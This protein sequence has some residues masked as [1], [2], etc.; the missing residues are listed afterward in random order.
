MDVMRKTII[1]CLAFCGLGFVGISANPS[2]ITITQPGLSEGYVAPANKEGIAGP[3]YGGLTGDVWNKRYRKLK[4]LEIGLRHYNIQWAGL[5]SS[6]LPSSSTP[7]VCPAGYF[8][9]PGSPEEKAAHHYK[10]Y[11]CLNVRTVNLFDNML[12]RDAGVGIQSMAILWNTPPI[13]QDSAC[14]G[15]TWKGAIE[16]GGCVPRDDAMDD[17]EDYVRF[18]GTRYNGGAHG[19]IYHFIVWNENAS[20]GWFDYSPRVNTLFHPLNPAE[21][22]IWIDKY[23]EMMIRTRDAL[24]GNTSGV[25]V[26]AS[27]DPLWEPPAHRTEAHIGSRVLLEGLWERLGARY[28]WS[29]AVH[30]YGNP[31]VPPRPGFYSFYN[32]EMVARFQEEHLARLGVA[33]SD[34]LHHPQAILLASEQGWPQSIGIDNQAKAVCEAYDKAL[35]LPNLIGLTHNLFQSFEASE[36]D[37]K[38]MGEGAVGVHFGLLPYRSQRDLSDM[39]SYPTGRAFESTRPSVWGRSNDHYC[40]QE[41]QLGCIPR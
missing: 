26:Y 30:P 20:G 36:T 12:A 17:Y 28:T 4:D 22:K 1:F 33:R 39:D 2:S 9:V 38:A 37:P 21:I 31:A 41:W 27:I 6:G 23:A 40:C 24:I 8:L 32:L 11:R 35:Q 3:P 10:R 29:V 16:K 13:Y 34:A 25:L 15:M 14:H 5:E 18:L 19:K 7:L